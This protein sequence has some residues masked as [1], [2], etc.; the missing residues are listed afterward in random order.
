MNYKNSILNLLN[1]TCGLGA[2]ELPVDHSSNNYSANRSRFLLD[3]DFNYD[4]WVKKLQEEV[5]SK[6]SRILSVSSLNTRRPYVLVKLK[7]DC[8]W[9]VMIYKP[10]P[11]DPRILVVRRV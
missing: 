4:E 7:G 10:T 9:K 11:Y 8:L 2:T 5:L 3:E 6:D 1:Q